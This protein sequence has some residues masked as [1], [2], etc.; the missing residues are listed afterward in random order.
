MD[1]VSW[2]RLVFLR[3]RLDQGIG[4]GFIEGKGEGKDNKL[5]N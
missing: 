2:V 5:I 1:W 4:E 3:M